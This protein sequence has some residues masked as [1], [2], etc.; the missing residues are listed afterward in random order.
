MRRLIYLLAAATLVH[1]VASYG[2]RQKDAG[3]ECDPS[4][5]DVRIAPPPPDLDC[6]DISFSSFH[7]IGSDPHH[8]DAD[9]DG[10]G[11]EPFRRR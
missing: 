7:V 1:A 4:Y 5:P 6:P 8:F 3:P 10:V 2:H 11:C 9:H